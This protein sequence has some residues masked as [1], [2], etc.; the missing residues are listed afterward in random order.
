MAGENLT[1]DTG[2]RSANSSQNNQIRQNNNT[3][4][5]TSMKLAHSNINSIRNKIDD[6][7]SE[8]SDYEIICISDDNDN[9]NLSN[10]KFNTILTETAEEFIPKV[11]FTYRPNEK[12]WM[13]SVIRKHM[14]QRDRLYHKAK[15]K[16]NDTHWLNFKNKRNQVV[17]MVRDAK[18]SYINKLQN[19]LADPNLSS[20]HWYKIANDITKM[21]NKSNPPPPLIQNGNPNIHPL[22][23]A[24]VLNDHFVNISTIDTDKEINE[25][26]NPPNFSLDTIIVTEQDVKDQLCN[27]NSSK[28]GGPDEIMPPLIK[29]FN[30]NLV[31]PLIIQKITAIRS[32]PKPMENCKCLRNLQR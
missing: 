19:K 26:L 13:D 11:S 1:H 21:K 23:K 9:I 30:T 22:D 18:K 15:T 27:L 32:S 20:K 12:P 16:N 2:N 8:L 24:Q 10:E 14:R 6:I 3:M 7:A 28:P 4:Q 25:K 17:Q 5:M 29:L 31:K